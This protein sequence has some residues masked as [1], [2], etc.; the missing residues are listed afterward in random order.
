[1]PLNTLRL[2]CMESI[3]A[4]ATPA[5]D[6]AALCELFHYTKF[7]KAFSVVRSL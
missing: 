1:M 7:A 3:L 2:F 5:R 6:T 4:D